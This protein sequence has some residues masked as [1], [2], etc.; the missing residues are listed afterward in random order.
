[1]TYEFKKGVSRDNPAWEELYNLLDSK[2]FS[3]LDML[4]CVCSNLCHYPDG[5]FSTE[6]MCGGNEFKIKI[7]K[8][9]G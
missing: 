2:G 6:L 9:G 3:V 4:A 7:E 8:K 1:M 5:E